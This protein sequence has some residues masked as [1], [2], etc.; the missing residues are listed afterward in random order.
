M[1]SSSTS[2]R[3]EAMPPL[4][5]PS[6]TDQ[7]RRIGKIEQQM[8]TWNGVSKVLGGIF[9][10]FGMSIVGIFFTTYGTSLSLQ[11]DIEVI[12]Q[13]V[14]EEKIMMAKTNE[15]VDLLKN[16][17]VVLEGWMKSQEYRQKNSQKD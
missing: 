12:K 8:A 7:G 1:A 15:Q 16:R 3:E 11:K 2:S 9:A 13:Y 6:A 10:V 4:P 5:S 14:A 17:V